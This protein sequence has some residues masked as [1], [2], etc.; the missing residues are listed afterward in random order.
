MQEK[1]WRQPPLTQSLLALPKFCD[2][3]PKRTEK[4]RALAVLPAYLRLPA[5]AEPRHRNAPAAEVHSA[6]RAL[7]SGSGRPPAPPKAIALPVEEAGE[8]KTPRGPLAARP[9]CATAAATNA[10]QATSRD[11]WLSRRLLWG[12][13]P[14]RGT[15]ILR[16][17]GGGATAER[18][19]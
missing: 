5:A 3:A 17:D 9:P 14:Q 7:G 13:G 1:S 2:S 10:A 15:G 19:D 16:H 11:P 4:P 18:G 6:G 8:P 12:Q